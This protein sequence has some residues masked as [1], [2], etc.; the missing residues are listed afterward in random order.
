MDP[1]TQGALGAAAAEAISSRDRVAWAGLLGGLSGMAP[2]LDVLIRS[3]NDPLLFLEFH[4]QFTHAFAFIPVGGLLCAMALFPV[5]RTRFSFI[6]TY[7]F[8]TL[9]WA[10]HGLLDACTSYGTQLF[11]PL[12]DLRVAWNVVSV[13]DP[14][15]TLPLV[16]LAGLAAMRKAPGLA[17]VGLAWVL[18]L[19]AL[20]TVQRGRAESFGQ[21]VAQARGHHHAEIVAKPSFGNLLLWKTIYAHG[22]RYYVDA[23]RLGTEP[24][25]FLGE[26]VAAL[27]AERDLPWLTPGT[28]QALDLERFRWFS[29]GFLARDAAEPTRVIDVRYSMLPNRIDG[30]WGIELDPEAAS[31]AHA[32]FFTEREATPAVRSELLRMLL[33]GRPAGEGD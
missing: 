6:R 17:R 5:V 3:S 18:A 1:L 32:Q 26:S 30:L 2:D 27:D 23:V 25:A 13:V 29:D 20:G 16:L 22:G 31:A 28:Q 33:P 11:W 9:G 24:L 10:T 12:S 19:L 15:V 14:L 8:C 7:A 4:R 21:A